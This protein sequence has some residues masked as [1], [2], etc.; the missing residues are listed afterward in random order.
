MRGTANLAPP[1]RKPWIAGVPLGTMGNF[2][3]KGR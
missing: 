2:E 1:S 3:N